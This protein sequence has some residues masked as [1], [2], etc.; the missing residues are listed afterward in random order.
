MAVLMRQTNIIW[1]GFC[2][3]IEIWTIISKNIKKTSNEDFTFTI[4]SVFNSGLIFEALET[5]VFLFFFFSQ[6][7][8]NFF[9]IILIIEAK[10]PKVLSL[11]LEPYFQAF[12]II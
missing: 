10:N 2:T 1:V 9:R 7:L 6:L 3:I 5:N 4:V 12:I 11:W 8:E